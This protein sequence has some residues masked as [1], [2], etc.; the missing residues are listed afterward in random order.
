M[1]VQLPSLTQYQ[2]DND[3]NNSLKLQNQDP[4]DKIF[5]N[6]KNLK[7]SENTAKIL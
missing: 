2:I 7:N 4:L 3:I 5:Q 1:Q 6:S